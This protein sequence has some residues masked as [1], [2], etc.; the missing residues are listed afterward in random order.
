[1]A[2]VYKREYCRESFKKFHMLLP[3]SGYLLTLIPFM[4]EN[5]EMFQN[6]GSMHSIQA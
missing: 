2:G 1:M 5:L 4:I 3:S 6:W